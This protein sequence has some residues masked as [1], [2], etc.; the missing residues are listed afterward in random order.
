MM[1][2]AAHDPAFARKVGVPVKVAKEFNAA[3]QAE[4]CVR[5]MTSAGDVGIVPSG[6]LRKKGDPDEEEGVSWHEIEPPSEA[7]KRL[8]RAAEGRRYSVA[9]L[10]EEFSADPGQVAVKYVTGSLGW[11]DVE[12]LKKKQGHHAVNGP[13]FLVLV[14]GMVKVGRKMVHQVVAL[15]VQNGEVVDEVDSVDFDRA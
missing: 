5:E 8:A 15:L 1:A 14:R 2:A 6:F 13:E 10:V 3:D 7:S 9:A 4:G 11:R 12:V